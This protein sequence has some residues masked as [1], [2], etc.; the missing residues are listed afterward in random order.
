[1]E[2]IIVDQSSSDN[3]P[4]LAKRSGAKY[5]RIPRPLYYSPPSISRNIGA[6]KA[7]GK[8][9]LH[10][11]ADMSFPKNLIGEIVSKFEKNRETPAIIIHETD[12]TRGFWSKSKALER[13]CYWGNSEIESARAVRKD[14]FRDI[15]GY[16]ES[17]SSGEDFDIQRKYQA[18]GNVLMSDTPIFHDLT[19]F[20]L[21]N[22]IFKKFNYGKSADKYFSKNR[23]SGNQI[24]MTEFKCYLKNWRMLLKDP[25]HLIGILIL[26][27]AEF[28]AG[29][30]GYILSRYEISR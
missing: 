1:V 23:T 17:V 7:A 2:I 6:A 3:T 8:Y 27:T 28:G 10:I 30:A 22:D 16:D 14:V 15:Q 4:E 18:A 5:I 13:K 29:A 9:F 19:N 25:L 24:L 26:K 11:D 21:K 12:L 20:N